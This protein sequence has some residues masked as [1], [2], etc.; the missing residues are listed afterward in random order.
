VHDVSIPSQKREIFEILK[1]MITD[2]RQSNRAMQT[3]GVMVDVVANFIFNCNPSDGLLKTTD[4]RRVCPLFCAQQNVGDKERDGMV[5]DYFPKLVK[6]L[7][8]D[9]YSI[10]SELLHTWP[11]PDEFNPTSDCTEA[12]V[13]TSTKRAIEASTGSIEQEVRE[14]IDQGLPGFRGGWVSSIMLDKLLEGLGVARRISRFK[15][16]EML[17]NMGY[18]LHPALHDGRVNNT[19]YPDGGKPRLFIKMDAPERHLTG[20]VLVAKAY[21]DA[22]MEMFKV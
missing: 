5:G 3:E 16:K 19:I 8:A 14:A 18:V 6:W 20:A 9:G 12:P 10:V 22:N 11:I 1:P 13:T 4:D 7:K 21:E 17:Q 15:R 2:K